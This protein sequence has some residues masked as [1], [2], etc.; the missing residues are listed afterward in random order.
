MK[1]KRTL[2]SIVLILGILA[3][4]TYYWNWQMLHNVAVISQPT[5]VMSMDNDNENDNENKN[6]NERKEKPDTPSKGWINILVLGTDA[7]GDEVARTDSIMLVLTNVDTQ[8]V[9]V[10][11]IP[12]DTRVNIPRV[13]LTKIN[14]ANA[15]GETKGGVREGT[16][17]SANA[18]SN[19]LGVT[20]NYYVKVN[21][22]GFEKVIDTIGGIVVDL[23]NPVNDD[24]VNIHLPAGENHLSGE[25]ALRLA[26]TR[27]GLPNGDFD[28]QQDQF[29]LLSALANQMLSIQNISKLPEEITIIQQELVDTN[30][31]TAEM[32]A[33][34]FAFKGIT[35]DAI[36]YYQ[37]PGRGITGLD[38]LVG[39]NIY[40]YEPDMEG[41]GK[42]VQ[43]ALKGR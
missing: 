23:P 34:G 32:V 22:Q 4:G 25:K 43:E 27:H 7:R 33:M 29:Y 10:I 20:I 12:R 18:V 24:K 26:R 6:E 40:Y 3:G 13:G 19:L 8:Q 30:L 37:L 1:I 38:P 35:K 17:E 36:K 28:R 16:L 15:V 11:S 41:I 31:S 39:A 21:F 5:V 14:H 2:W 42:V 9:S